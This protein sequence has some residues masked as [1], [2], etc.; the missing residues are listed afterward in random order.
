LKIGK[1]NTILSLFTAY[2]LTL[3]YLLLRLQQALHFANKKLTI[4]NIDSREK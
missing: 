4:I 3:S 2:F 1:K